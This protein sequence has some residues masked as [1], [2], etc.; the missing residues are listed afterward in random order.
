MFKGKFAL[1]VAVIVAFVVVAVDIVH[2]EIVAVAE[3][4][5]YP[6]L[7]CLYLRSVRID[8][9]FRLPKKNCKPFQLLIR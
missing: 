2:C 7:E 4:A 5:R 1:S 8:D 3:S 9:F 6:V